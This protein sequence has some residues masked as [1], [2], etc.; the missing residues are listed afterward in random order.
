MM[1]KKITGI[2]LIILLTVFTLIACSNDEQITQTALNE[3]DQ[4]DVQMTNIPEQVKPN[5]ITILALPKMN[6]LE[7]YNVFTI[8]KELFEQ[9]H[10][11]VTVEIIE[12]PYANYSG[13]LTNA[14]ENNQMP[15][16]FFTWPWNWAPYV[17]NGWV[18]NLDPFVKVEEQ[19]LFYENINKQMSI[20]N[21]LVAQPF[22][23][24]PMTVAY[25]KKWFDTANIPYPNNNWTWEQFIEIAKKIQSANVKGSEKRYGAVFPYNLDYIE[26]LIVGKGGRLLSDD[27]KK[28][29]GYFDG[30]ES[31][32][33]FTWINDLINVHKVSPFVEAG[34]IATLDQL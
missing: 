25:N 32:E 21:E 16:I 6:M 9:K 23:V 27:G 20:N 11:G 28:A 13:Y 34:E 4:N 3:Q 7:A 30:K 2:T 24:I 8:G 17:K 5:K 10:P 22:H 26:T 15:D 14:F 33:G 12:V 31:I 1:F 29:R 19:N 18:T